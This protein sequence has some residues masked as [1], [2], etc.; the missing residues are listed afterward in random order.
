[1]LIKN[2]IGDLGDAVSTTEVPIPN[3]SSYPSCTHSFVI[4]IH[5]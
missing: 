2:M 4:L 5:F 1:M 3:V